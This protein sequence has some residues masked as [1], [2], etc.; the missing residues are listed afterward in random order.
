MA[1]QASAQLAESLVCE[2]ADGAGTHARRLG[3]GP[4]SWIVEILAICANAWGAA[5]AYEDLSR[6][7]DAEL[8]RRGIP[9]GKLHRHV[10]DVLTKA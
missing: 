3:A 10:F 1:H 4:G 8:E 2:V 5:H 7:S 9:R 6:L